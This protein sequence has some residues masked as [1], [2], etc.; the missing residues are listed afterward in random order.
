MTL[1]EPS[2]PNPLLEIDQEDWSGPATPEGAAEQKLEALETGA[3]LF[4]PK[5]AFAITA[6]E[7]AFFSPSILSKSKN[8]SFDP[9]TGKV[10]GTICVGEEKE[11]LGAMM[12]RFSNCARQLLENLLPAYRGKI[13]TGRV[14]FRPAEIA[15]RASSWRKDDSLLH[16]DAFPTTPTNGNRILR[17]FC[18]VNPRGK[19]RTWR[20]GEPFEKVAEKFAPALRP[21]VWGSST[22]L[23]VLGLTKS[24]RSEYDH[25]MLQ[26]HD[27]MKRD[28]DYQAQV[29]QTRCDFPPGSTWMVFVD[30]VSH[31]AVAGQY[32]LE[33]TFYL[34][35]AAMKQERL[36]PLRV[37]ER[38]LGR[39]LV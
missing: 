20:L 5:L 24:R 36:A 33:Q 9:S 37:L 31:A 15:G 4:F 18:N 12:S 11:K 25:L 39:R 34:P 1:R 2:M 38:Q 29:E 27:E 16:I 14:S 19:P 7:Q 6:K 21:P 13:A 3:V 28:T 23:W 8:V 22:A 17:M 30:A 35:L 26:L 10:G 32:Q